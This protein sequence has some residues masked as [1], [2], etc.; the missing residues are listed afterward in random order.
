MKLN[1]SRIKQWQALASFV[2]LDL[3]YLSS[4]RVVLCRGRVRVVLSLGLRVA[5]AVGRCL[6]PVGVITSD[7]HETS[8]D[9]IELSTLRSLG[10]AVRL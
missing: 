6:L 1:A 3:L 10:F 5:I 7:C 9:R 2:V 8:I 4:E